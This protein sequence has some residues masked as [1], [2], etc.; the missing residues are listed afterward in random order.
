MRV[1]LNQATLK[2]IR[3]AGLYG[4]WM[5][6]TYHKGLA[7]LQSGIGKSPVVT[8]TFAFKDCQRGF[9]LLYQGKAIKGAIGFVLEVALI[10]LS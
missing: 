7:I 10:T 5:L 2:N 4:R 3:L 8:K 1:D 9:D 6:D